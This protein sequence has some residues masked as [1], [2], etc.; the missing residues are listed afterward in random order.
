[1][2]IYAKFGSETQQKITLP[3]N[4]LYTGLAIC[5]MDSP[6]SKNFH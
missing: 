6:C 1:M 5:G 2:N 4:K 3:K